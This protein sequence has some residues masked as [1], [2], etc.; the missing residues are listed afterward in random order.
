MGK[1]YVYAYLLRFSQS[2]VLWWSSITVSDSRPDT[3]STLVGTNWAFIFEETCSAN[4]LVWAQKRRCQTPRPPKVRLS[5]GIQQVCLLILCFHNFTSCHVI[6]QI[7]LCWI[8]YFCL[9]GKLQSYA[10]WSGYSAVPTQETLQSPFLP[11]LGQDR[12]FAFGSLKFW[13]AWPPPGTP[14]TEQLCNPRS[15]SATW[16]LRASDQAFDPSVGPPKG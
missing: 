6:M 14:K 16:H 4:R 13:W 11:S 9:S 15:Q 1:T 7:F 2:S 3:P 8:R 12:L 5:E 10:G